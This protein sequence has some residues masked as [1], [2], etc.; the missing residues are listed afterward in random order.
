V[1]TWPFDHAVNRAAGNSPPFR[2]LTPA[3]IVM[4]L[5]GGASLALIYICCV[6][7]VRRRWLPLLAP[8]LL[9]GLVVF[10]GESTRVHT[11][12]IQVALLLAA[13]VASNHF[14]ASRR[15]WTFYLALVLAGL[16]CAV[17]FS[18]GPFVLASLAVYGIRHEQPSRRLARGVAILFVPFAVFVAVNPYLYPDPIRRTRSL[19]ASWSISKH[20][21]QE[22][23]S[24]EAVTSMPQRFGLVASKGVLAPRFATWSGAGGDIAGPAGAVLALG[25]LGLAIRGALRARDRSRQRR[26]FWIAASSSIGIALLAVLDAFAALLPLLAVAGCVQLAVLAR[27][28]E[29]DERSA[30][31]RSFIIVLGA[32]VVAT[33][34]WLPLDWSRYYLPVIALMP[35]VYV[36]GVAELAPP[37]SSDTSHRKLRLA[38]P[39]PASVDAS[40]PRRTRSALHGFAW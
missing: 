38:S 4:A 30:V 15:E 12:M 32:F 22:R 2:L 27:S 31:V 17:K 11:D 10:V 39:T 19:I 5:F 25:L 20:M 40:S 8:I 24:D 14:L 3:R 6:Q 1:T 29:R 36:A 16:S 9:F 33:A 23:F 13:I 21:Q 37:I 7:V 35:V 26:L 34:L 18:S 28:R